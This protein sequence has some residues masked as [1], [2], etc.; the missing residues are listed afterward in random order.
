M[1]TRSHAEGAHRAI[2]RSDYNVEIIIAKGF[3]E[4]LVPPDPAHVLESGLISLLRRF[5]L[6]SPD[7]PRLIWCI[8]GKC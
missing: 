1:V 3:L 4:S 5:L 2:H 7:E 6:D 8:Y